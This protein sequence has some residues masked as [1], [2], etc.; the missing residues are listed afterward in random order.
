MIRKT[1]FWAHLVV[2]LA[3]GL[4]LLVLAVTGVLLTY[5][6]QITRWADGGPSAVG[7]RMDAGA[8]AEAALAATDGKAT[9]LVIENDP[10]QPVRATFRRGG[11]VRLDPATG[12][13]LGE[14][15][16]GLG[17]FFGAVTRL[18]RWLTLDGPG[19]VGG[20]IVGAANLG[21]LFLLLTG[22]YLW[23]PRIWRGPM[24]RLRTWPRRH[25]PDAKARDYA[26]HHVFGFWAALP[27]MLIVGSGVTMS[28]GPAERLVL[29]VLGAQAGGGRPP[30]EAADTIDTTGLETA[31]AAAMAY[32]EGW[33]R[34]TLRL[35]GDNTVSATVDTGSGRR[36][37]AQTALT[38]AREGGEIT[39]V[40]PFAERPAG[41]RARLFLRFVHS[42]EYYGLV[43]QT[44]A[45]LASLAAAILVYTG[46]AQSWRRLVRPLLRRG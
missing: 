19:G 38:I 11:Q 13:V 25:Y 9:A 41:M 26:W 4:V 29:A 42:G 12:A 40:E 18:H 22:A 27:L 16:T 43:G 21:F 20:T 34:V 24:L 1:L 31:L 36:P 44:L 23:L 39:A 6:V 30:R 35:A 17:A 37:A 28:Y 7:V 46:F 10:V 2:G 45:G 33:N 32:D 5:E 14:G 3:A 15:E 8:L